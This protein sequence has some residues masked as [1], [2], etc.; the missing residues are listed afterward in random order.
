MMAN[1]ATAPQALSQFDS[2]MPTLLLL[3]ELDVVSQGFILLNCVC[4]F[5]VSSI[6]GHQVVV[7]YLFRMLIGIHYF[8]D[9]D[10]DE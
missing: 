6:D 7:V 8:D 3:K 9:E 5:T 1:T 2:P 10:E 4:H